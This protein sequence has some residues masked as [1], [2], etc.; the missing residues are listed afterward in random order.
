[1]SKI[2]ASVVNDNFRDN[3]KDYNE[4]YIYFKYFGDLINFCETNHIFLDYSD[5]LKNELAI[6]KIKRNIKFDNL[7]LINEK[8]ETNEK[9]KAMC[10]QD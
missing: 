1:M 9:I 6:E 5:Y 7:F 4:R 3:D 8:L 2:Y 10:I